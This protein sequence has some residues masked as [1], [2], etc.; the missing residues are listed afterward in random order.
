MSDQ[1]K[2]DPFGINL[3]RTWPVLAVMAIGSL[4]VLYGAIFW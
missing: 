2:P 1:P 3:R 4:V